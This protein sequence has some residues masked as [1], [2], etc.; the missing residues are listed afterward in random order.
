MIERNCHTC[1]ETEKDL[2]DKI[3]ALEA[4]NAALRGENAAYAAGEV[5][6]IDENAAGYVLEEMFPDG[7]IRVVKIPDTIAAKDATIDELMAL[8]ASY[9]GELDNPSPDVHMRIHWR[10]RMRAWLKEKGDE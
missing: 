9:I 5:V 4:E 6:C 2:L 7:S 8:I 1:A 10:N 3:A